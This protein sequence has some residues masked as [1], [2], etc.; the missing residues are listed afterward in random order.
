[1]WLNCRIKT[2]ITYYSSRNYLTLT[3]MN[4]V[5][6]HEDVFQLLMKYN[7]Q[8]TSF[9]FTLRSLN[10]KSRL[11]KGYWFLGDDY[12]LAVSFWSGND[13][14]TRMPRIAFCINVDGHTTLEFNSKDVNKVQF[15]KYELLRDLGVDPAPSHQVHYR[16]YYREFKNEDYILSLKSFVEKD[17]KIIDSAINNNRVF[18]P[19]VLEYTDPVGFITEAAFEKQETII[20][21]YRKVFERKSGQTGYLRSFDI[22]RFGP[23]RD[24]NINDIPEGCRW[25]FVT[26]ENGSGKTSILRALATGLTGNNDHDEEVAKDYPAFSV[27]IGLEKGDR[28][29]KTLIQS[30]SD[31]KNGK[32]LPR[33]LAVYG[34][35]RLLTQGSLDKHFQKSDEDHISH[36]TT[37]G[38][39]NP[40]GILRDIS[41]EYV[42]GVR[43][44]EY[45]QTLDSFIENIAENL[46]LI[47]PNVYKVDIREKG[48]GH[49]ILYYQG[50]EKTEFKRN[51]T[52]FQKL[53]SGT[54]N[55]AALILDMLLRFSEKQDTVTDLSDFVGIVL[56]DEIDLHL[57]PKL[58]RE[59][60]IQLSDTFPHIQF[61]VTTHS[62]I[63]MLG[64]PKNSVFINVYKDENENICANKLDIDITSWLPNSLL[65]S[66]LFGFDELINAN[67]VSGEKLNTEND[68]NEAVFYNILERKIRERTLERRPEE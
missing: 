34:P 35:V 7:R 33:G 31:Y 45:Q 41:G 53:S 24:A 2:K 20:A 27:E 65:T 56:I 15:F 22:R 55:F 29:E 4:L 60:V 11:E 54:R 8:D 68:Y 47:L 40:I 46:S 64:A 50:D 13:K 58:Q 37:Y 51:P 49:E 36:Q 59:I 48:K 66:P 63:P 57:H 62:P 28:V 67:H 61:I 25:I 39:F 10:R 38:L 16:R 19:D 44:K 23:V 30:I 52:P 32:M 3:L 6:I 12:Y 18:Y 26:G 21:K 9:R 42:L 14:L 5:Q 1:M 43:P 17:K